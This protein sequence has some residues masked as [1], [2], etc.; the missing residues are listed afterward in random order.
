MMRCP[1]V[2]SPSIDTPAWKQ[3]I[4]HLTQA[5]HGDEGG[6]GLTRVHDSAAPAAS[7][8]DE[9]AAAV[10]LHDE[11]DLRDMPQHDNGDGK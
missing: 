4:D 7:E 6:G 8:E 5:R 2:F 11:E 3:E 9:E 1:P 10:V